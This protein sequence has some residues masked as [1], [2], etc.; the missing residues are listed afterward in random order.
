MCLTET[1]ISTHVFLFSC[2]VTLKGVDCTCSALC[3]S[4]EFLGESE[5]SLMFILR[6]REAYTCSICCRV[7]SAVC[8]GQSLMTGR[9][10]WNQVQSCPVA[11][12]LL[13][14]QTLAFAILGWSE[15][16][17]ASTS[18]PQLCEPVETTVSLGQRHCSQSR[19]SGQ[20]GCWSLWPS[21]V[22]KDKPEQN[23]SR[24]GAATSGL[25]CLSWRQ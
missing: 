17:G 23:T 13:I 4:G 1:C 12:T 10:F 18:Q 22:V 6:G 9:Q 11:P 5:D 3:C 15:E 21:P 7:Q 2:F 24:N 14:L 25:W 8:L 20:P 16:D 19:F